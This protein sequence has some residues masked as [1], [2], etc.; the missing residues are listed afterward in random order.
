MTHV[1]ALASFDDTRF[2]ASNWAIP[3]QQP[4]TIK[5][6]YQDYNRLQAAF[7]SSTCTADEYRAQLA[8]IR[9]LAETEGAAATEAPPLYFF[10]IRPPAPNM[11]VPDADLVSAGRDFELYAVRKP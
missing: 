9:I 5:P 10:L 1:A 4:I 8:S 11:L 6:P 7:K 2:V 3:G